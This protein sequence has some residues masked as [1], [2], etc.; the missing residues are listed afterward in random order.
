MY[1]EQRKIWT[2]EKNKSNCIF[3]ISSGIKWLLNC[4]FLT[5]CG[6]FNES[7]TN[8]LF[9]YFFL[10]F[11]NFFERYKE[12]EGERKWA[13]SCLLAHP[14]MPVR[15]RAGRTPNPRTKHSTWVSHKDAE[16]QALEPF[17]TCCL[18]G[19]AGIWSRAGF[20]SVR[21]WA[22]HVAS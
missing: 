2:A 6:I 10:S 12:A 7:L 19:H 5:F 15:A 3:G 1:V 20:S 16:T 13:K 17:I 8:D 18:L 11:Y 9:I 14:Q 22:F 21:M 4:V